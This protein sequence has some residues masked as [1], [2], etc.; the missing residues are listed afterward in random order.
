M[1]HHRALA[2]AEQQ[3]RQAAIH[4]VAVRTPTEAARALLSHPRVTNPRD[5]AFLGAVVGR[6][7]RMPPD[8]YGR[9]IQLATPLMSIETAA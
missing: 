7:G 6:T 5:V 1:H 3:Q 2:A 4:F 9:M 8:A